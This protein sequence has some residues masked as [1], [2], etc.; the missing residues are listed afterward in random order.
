[1]AKTLHPLNEKCKKDNLSFVRMTN[2]Q[3]PCKD[4]E[5]RYNDG[6]IYTN[7]YKCAKYGKKDMATLLGTKKCP[8]YAKEGK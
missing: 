7:T 5:W 6:T 2:D 1:M 8:K 4:C 3:L